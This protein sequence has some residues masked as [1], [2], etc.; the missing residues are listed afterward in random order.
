[1]KFFIALLMVFVLA[2][3]TNQ[4]GSIFTNIP[5]DGGQQPT[6]FN[7]NTPLSF[8]V[9]SLTNPI[10]KNQVAQ[11]KITAQGRCGIFKE[12]ITPAV[13][14]GN[15]VF[16]KTFSVVGTQDF[17]VQVDALDY[18]QLTVLETISKSV[19]ITVQD[20]GGTPPPP[21]PTCVITKEASIY[22]PGAN[23]IV[24]VTVTG[25]YSTLTLNNVPIIS[26]QNYQMPPVQAGGNYYNLFAEAVN[27]QGVHG[28]CSLSFSTPLQTLRVISAAWDLVKI[29]MALYGSYT[30]IFFDGAQQ[31]LPDTGNLKIIE[32]VPTSYGN[33]TGI[34]RLINA[35][36]VW[37]DENTQN[38]N[39]CV[40]KQPFTIAGDT[41]V[42]YCYSTGGFIISNSEPTI[43]AGIQHTSGNDNYCGGE[44]RIKVIKRSTNPIIKTSD[45][46]VTKTYDCDSDGEQRVV[47]GFTSG[48]INSPI[49]AALLPD[50][51]IYSKTN[52]NLSWPGTSYSCPSDAVMIGSEKQTSWNY[53][54][55]TCGKIRWKTNCP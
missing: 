16:N 13:F 49:C 7:C 54:R 15:T 32:I 27:A 21:A 3:C 47:V 12:Y 33:K 5:T 35:E 50:L 11:F 40:P 6:G 10:I 26:G 53:R 25:N 48:S 45:V 36:P 20:D 37:D 4:K 44:S 41:E 1:M 39:Y 17:I 23:S 34:G 31:T 43:V 2:S 9:Q 29:E 30:H 19:S 8:T 52:Y 14:T 38:I 55:V 28:Y 18:D 46:P 51:E 22:Q 42:H 24:K